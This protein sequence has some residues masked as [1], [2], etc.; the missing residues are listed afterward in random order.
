MIRYRWIGEVRYGHFAEY[1]EIGEELRALQRA[2]GLR[3][4]A[5]W[6][7][8]VGTGNQIIWEIEYPDL[9]T[10]ESETERFYSDAEIMK[11][12][13]RGSEL[14]VQGT[15]RDELLQPAPHIA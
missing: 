14:I 2:R 9:A 15:G 7:P 13:R 11:L 10:F 3:E 8:T 4:G 12:V 5:L 1:V 6:V